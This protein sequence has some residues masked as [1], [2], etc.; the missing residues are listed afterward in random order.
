ML[1]ESF[2][3]LYQYFL[4]IEGMH[5]DGKVSASVDV[6]Y[7]VPLSSVLGPLLFKLYT[8]KLFLIVK[9]HIVGCADDTT[10]YEVIPRVLSRSQVVGSLNQDLVAMNSWR[11]KWHMRLNSK[12]TKSMVV[13]RSRIIA[14]GYS[15][16]TLSSAVLDALKSLCILGA[17][18]D[19]KLTFDTH[20][21]EVMSKAAR[22]LGVVRRA[23]KLFVCPCVLKSV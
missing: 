17:T 3:S 21:R 5:L 11:L 22:N 10:V 1:K 4:K 18:V 19:S 13:S 2:C 14:S 7:G 9:N 8:S 12:K 20:L 15:D 16:P 6:V 23:R